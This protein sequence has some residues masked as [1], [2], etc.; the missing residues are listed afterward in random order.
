MRAVA[1]LLT[2]FLAFLL[3][4]THASAHDIALVIAAA[5]AGQIL[6]TVGAARVHRLSARG[7]A[8]LSPLL[9]LLACSAAAL[10]PGGILPALAAGVTGLV[11]STSK[12][13]LDATLQS[14]VQ[15]RSV[16]SAFA[17]SE[18]ALQL[19]WVV[20]AGIALAL[21]ATGSVGFAMGAVL[22]AAGAV[23]AVRAR[24]IRPSAVPAPGR[25]AAG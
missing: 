1:G 24:P 12:F 8:R 11:S 16:S 4:A 3:R 5:A 13:A 17:R 25:P 18:T 6:G 2:I 14:D 21:P 10:R 15:P 23:A 9:S 20:G 7:V 19:A 22:S